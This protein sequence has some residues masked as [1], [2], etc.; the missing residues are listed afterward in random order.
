MMVFY[1]PAY[2]QLLGNA[3]NEKKPNKSLIFRLL[4]VGV[5]EL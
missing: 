5:V 2:A 1:D 3:T 4:L